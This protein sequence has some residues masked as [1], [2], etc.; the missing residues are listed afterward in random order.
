MNK[1]FFLLLICR[2]FYV[3]NPSFTHSME[4]HGLGEAKGLAQN[5][6]QESCL[7]RGRGLPSQA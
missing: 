1:A 2:I 4:G 7:I 6:Q 3:K 5:N